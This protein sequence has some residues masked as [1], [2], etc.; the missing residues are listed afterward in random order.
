M[1][2]PKSLQ[3]AGSARLPSSARD[4]SP[5]SD[6][7]HGCGRIQVNIAGDVEEG[8]R[9]GE[10]PPNDRAFHDVPAVG[11]RR[12]PFFPPLFLGGRSLPP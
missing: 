7:I 2:V 11:P 5:D 3:R 8:S 9:C 10:A 6:M 12:P 1:S 4:F